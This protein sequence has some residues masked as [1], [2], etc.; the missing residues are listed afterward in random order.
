MRRRRP[1]TDGH[2]KVGRRCLVLSILVL[3]SV[4]ITLAQYLLTRAS[5]RR[6]RPCTDRH[7]KVVRRCLVLSILILLP[8]SITL[9]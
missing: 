3:L 6:Q 7:S 9:V 1:C 2:S 5:M 4:S 8:V